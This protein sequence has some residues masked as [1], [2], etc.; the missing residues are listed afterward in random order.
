MTI[1]DSGTVVKEV[2]E[3]PQNLMASVLIQVKLLLT[4]VIVHSGLL[5]LILPANVVQGFPELDSPVIA[6]KVELLRN[7]DTIDY[8]LLRFMLRARGQE[9]QDCPQLFSSC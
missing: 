2:L 4:T 5:H 7:K 8:R 3:G 9:G 1:I 6:D